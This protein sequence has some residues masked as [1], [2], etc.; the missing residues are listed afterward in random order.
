M[1]NYIAFSKQDFDIFD[2][3]DP[4]N[5]ILTGNLQHVEDD[6]IASAAFAAT[7]PTSGAIFYVPQAAAYPYWPLLDKSVIKEVLNGASPESFNH[8]QAQIADD[9]SPEFDKD[10][11]TSDGDIG[12]RRQELP[13][14]GGTEVKPP[15]QLL[16]GLQTLAGLLIKAGFRDTGPRSLLGQLV[17]FIVALVLKKPIPSRPDLFVL[18]KQIEQALLNPHGS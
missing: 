10:W 18:I 8:W 5:P 13:Q 4:N 7:L 15:E 16:Q 6:V 17:P 14:K 3:T 2:G 12:R 9:G 11:P 1:R